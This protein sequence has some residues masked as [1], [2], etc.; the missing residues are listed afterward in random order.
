MIDLGLP[1]IVGAVVTVVVCPLLVAIVN[2]TW[3]ERRA[4]VGRNGSFECLTTTF[5]E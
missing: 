3:K 2:A 1:Y 5:A 4:D